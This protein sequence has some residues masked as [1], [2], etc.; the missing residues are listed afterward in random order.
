[1]FNILGILYSTVKEM[2]FQNEHTFFLNSERVAMSLIN[3]KNKK[4]LKL[5]SSR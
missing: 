1:M 3:C 4:H 5:A 2:I